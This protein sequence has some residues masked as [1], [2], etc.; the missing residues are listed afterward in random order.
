MSPLIL[1]SKIGRSV[2][3][4]LKKNYLIWFIYNVQMDAYTKFH[5]DIS[6]I[7]WHDS[8]YL[9]RNTVHDGNPS[10]IQKVLYSIADSSQK[11]LFF[12]PSF[13]H[14][15]ICIYCTHSAVLLPSLCL[16]WYITN[17]FLGIN[18]SSSKSNNQSTKSQNVPSYSCICFGC[19][20]PC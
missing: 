13:L 10:W 4:L 14:S 18:I 17:V 19:C 2:F 8:K 9:A 12:I 16:A 15:G 5:A 20:C 7:K 6:I 11:N 3:S 1:C